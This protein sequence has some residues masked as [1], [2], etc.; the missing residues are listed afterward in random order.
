MHPD[1]DTQIEGFFTGA[2]DFTRTNDP[3]ENE[4][5]SRVACFCAAVNT[6]NEDIVDTLLQEGFD[7]NE[8]IEA[9]DQGIYV[10]PLT[11]A[12]LDGRFDMAKHLIARGAEV[13]NAPFETPTYGTTTIV[14]S[15]ELEPT[16]AISVIM[17]LE[18]I[19]DR[20]KAL[21]SDK[22]TDDIS[23]SMRFTLGR[24]P[25]AAACYMKSAD[26]IQALLDAGAEFGEYYYLALGFVLD[27]EKPCTDE[28]TKELLH[29]VLSS[30]DRI[31]FDRFIDASMDF[32]QY[33]NGE[34]R[35]NY[36]ADDY[37]PSDAA[38]RRAWRTCDRLLTSPAYR[39]RLP[40]SQLLYAKYCDLTMDEIVEMVKEVS[41][42]IDS[43]TDLGALFTA[44]MPLHARRFCL[45]TI[46]PLQVSMVPNPATKK[47]VL[48]AFPKWH[49][50]SD[51]T[52]VQEAFKTVVLPLLQEK[53]PD[54]EFD[55]ELLNSTLEE[56]AIVGDQSVAQAAIGAAL[57]SEHTVK[58]YRGMYGDEI[59]SQL[60]MM[61]SLVYMPKL[62]QEE[63]QCLIYYDD[64]AIRKVIDFIEQGD[65]G[66]VKNYMKCSYAYGFTQLIQAKATDQN[67][68]ERFSTFALLCGPFITDELS[69][70]YLESVLDDKAI[71]ELQGMFA[72]IKKA[73][74]LAIEHSEHLSDETRDKA[75]EKLEGIDLTIVGMARSN[76]PLEGSLIIDDWN[77]VDNTNRLMALSVDREL[78]DYLSGK[79]DAST[80]TVGRAWDYNACYSLQTNNVELYGAYLLPP[81]YSPRRSSVMN[82]AAIGRV[83]G[84]ELSHAFDPKSILM[85]KA[86]GGEDAAIDVFSSSPT[87]NENIEKLKTQFKNKIPRR[88]K[89]AYPTLGIYQEF[90]NE[91]CVGENFA[92]VVGLE[93]AL[94]AY[95]LSCGY[96]SISVLVKE[97]VDDVKLFMQS[98]A[99]SLREK[100]SINWL[101]YQLMYDVHAPNEFRV[102]TVKNLDAFHEVYGTKVGDGMWLEPEERVRVFG[103]K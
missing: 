57:G 1:T 95:A 46:M 40:M 55:L 34:W 76:A 4:S 7:L 90:D 72:D 18:A 8:T 103:I 82:Y 19:R 53:A 24:S 45:P 94:Y 48:I 37:S 42:V 3:S 5:I 92:D 62:A 11:T 36:A 85:L 63:D 12:I 69:P 39:K 17:G 91:K 38:Q 102:N 28:E 6:G 89:Q 54:V 15:M 25:L 44:L 41:E 61:E 26:T 80:I 84:H 97:K 100:P 56:I 60:L 43:A 79:D 78:T 30:R 59:D 75:L 29:L 99:L 83:I 21:N 64:Q 73:Y 32:E 98:Y 93:I 68:E 66:Q 10:R 81:A 70:V 35:R 47:K 9:A 23:P 33:V 58:D 22:K 51:E 101:M 31:G 49:N 96:S 88:L 71:S 2:Y 14:K 67:A 27:S 52:G 77:F 20:F 74:H 65:L 50:T 87:Y 13:G 16:K 86:M